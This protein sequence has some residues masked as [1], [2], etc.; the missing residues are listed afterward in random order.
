M[1][2]PERNKSDVQRLLSQISAEHESGQ[3]ALHSFAYGA[4]KH[5]FI[6]ARMERMHA[7]HVLLAEQVGED[8]ASKMISDHLEGQ[9]PKGDK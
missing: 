6:T 8:E 2:T 9:E 5:E 4:A 1:S 7:L 3:R